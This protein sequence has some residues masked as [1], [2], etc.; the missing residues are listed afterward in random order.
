VLAGLALPAPAA[1]APNVVVIET[2]DQT[3]ADLE[4]MPRTREL[5]AGEGVTFRESFVSLSQCCPS[6]ATLLTGRYAHNH[7]VLASAPPLGGVDRLDASETLA[8]WLRRAGYATALVGKY[9]NGYGRRNPFAVP[10]GWTEWHVLLGGSTYRYYDYAINHDGRL[11]GYGGAPEDYQ[12]DVITTLTEGVVRRRAAARAPFFLWTAY[13]APHTGQPR[14]ILDPP[15]VPSAVPAPRHRDAFAGRLP[16]FSPAFDEADVSDKPLAIAT[17]PPLGPEATAALWEAW[18][19]RQEALQA[20]DE[21]VARIVRALRAAGE[22]RD[23]LIVFTSDNG[24]MTGEHRLA[25]GKIVPYE[26]S[27]RVP[28]L[29]RGPGIPAGAVRTQPVWNGD[30]APTILA[31]AGARSPWRPD[32]RSLWP[33]I[34]RPGLRTGRAIL[35]EGPPRHGL[36]RYAGLRTA[37]HLYVEHL[38][39]E[40]ELY[41]LARD[42]YELDN[43][44]AMPAAVPVRIRLAARLAR[45]RGCRGAGCRQ[46]ARGGAQPGAAYT[47]QE[48]LR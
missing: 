4:A 24:F 41:D 33:L 13:V 46:R 3:A 38:D 7:H 16:P 22:L 44:V 2:D 40:L 21:G 31:A 1:A 26:P 32:G 17:R 48:A 27:I 14:D 20:V 10:P 6:R 39:G 12:T 11:R 28:L 15:G 18:R 47:R 23:T 29:M 5:I 34:R 9:L 25:A 19:Q 42:P 36:P 30:L 43:L 8:V 37:R 45:L 35:L